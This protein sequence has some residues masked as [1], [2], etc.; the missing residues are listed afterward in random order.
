MNTLNF[1]H[2]YQFW[3]VAQEGSIVAAGHRLGVGH[4]TI[5]T[6]LRALETALG[7]RLMLRRPRG[8]RLTPLGE[9]VRT[10]CDEIFRL[11]SELQDVASG[12]RGRQTR[13]RVGML[14]SVPRSLLYDALEPIMAPDGRFAVE[15]RVGDLAALCSALVSGRL[16]V[17]IAD[18]L[19]TRPRHGQVTS[20]L[21]GQTRMGFYAQENL[22]RRFRRGFPASLDGAPVLLPA[23]GSGLREGI[24]AWFAENRIRPRIVGEFDD[25]PTMKGFA[26][27]GH[28]LVPI[29]EALAEEARQRYGLSRI[30]AIAGLKDRL[31]ALTL[32]RRMR[33]PA[34][35]ELLATWR[36]RLSRDDTAVT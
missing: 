27:R 9:T 14:A 31:Y 10:Y 32:G 19:P 20:Q 29:R 26:L 6:Q 35:Q 22:A 4:S 24:A 36:E 5:S 11:G 33:H 2:L 12:R 7:G 15:V 25:V 16:H 1:R 13:L 28:G 34:A 23:P 3:V 30:G 8:I 17:V 21:L 18:A